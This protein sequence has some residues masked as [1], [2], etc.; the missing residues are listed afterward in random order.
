MYSRGS[1]IL[2]YIVLMIFTIIMGV[3]LISGEI[4]LY[5]APR[6]LPMAWM[7]FGVLVILSG[8]QFIRMGKRLGAES[9]GGHEIQLQ[10][11]VFLIP[12][13]L[14]M[15]AMP[16]ENTSAALPNHNAQ[17]V[18]LA[19]QTNSGETGAGQSQTDKTVKNGSGISANN[20]PID[21]STAEPC[22]YTGNEVQYSESED[23]FKEY[24]NQTTAELLGRDIKIYGFVFHDDSYPENVI[25]VSRLCLYCC[26]AD[27]FVI[28]FYVKVEDADAFQS[29]D[30]VCV[31]GQVESITVEY[32]G[33]DG[34]F[35]I[36]TSGTISGSTAPDM[37]KAYIYP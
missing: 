23:L 29:D 5:L 36:I 15:T 1:E 17:A 12:I 7:G 11:L 9:G 26:A 8:Y 37:D 10:S 31:T 25:M 30:W 24:L 35:P 2:W 19:A 6:M 28:G 4:L 16:N 20:K 18:S 32:Y 27:S 14:M 34:D 13:I 21:P 22:V 33:E 3:L